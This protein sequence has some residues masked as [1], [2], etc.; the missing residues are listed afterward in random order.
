M[1]DKLKIPSS[2]AVIC[3]TKYCIQYKLQYKCVGDTSNSEYSIQNHFTFVTLS[4]R[5]LRHTY[6]SIKL[7]LGIY[8]GMAKPNRK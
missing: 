4:C 3:K 1:V 7:K 8:S 5:F 6:L 2:R